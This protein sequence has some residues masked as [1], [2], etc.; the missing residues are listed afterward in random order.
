MIRKKQKTKKEIDARIS[1][2]GVNEQ[3]RTRRLDLLSYQIEEIEAG[4]LKEN[5]E[6]E[7]LAS[8]LSVAHAQRGV[9][10]N[11]AKSFRPGAFLP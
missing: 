2:L 7:L 3:D 5:E 8:V 1:M 11:D 9:V 4:D 6:E 10:I